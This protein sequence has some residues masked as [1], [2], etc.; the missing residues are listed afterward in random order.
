MK[1][2]EQMKRNFIVLF[3][4]LISVLF[5]CSSEEEKFEQD[6]KESTTKADFVELNT[7]EKDNLKKPFHLTGEISSVGDGD[8]TVTTQE[9]DGFGIYSVVIHADFWDYIDPDFKAEIGDK[10]TVYGDYSG[11]DLHDGMLNITAKYIEEK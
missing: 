4:L 10:I 1:E 8:F 3:L 5:G 9:G 7:N 2:I 11:K 6:Y